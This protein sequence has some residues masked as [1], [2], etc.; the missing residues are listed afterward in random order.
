MKPSEDWMSNVVT[1]KAKSKL[2]DIFREE[3]RRI[4]SI[5]KKLLKIFSENTR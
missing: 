5:G 1:A 3:R 4:I 2:K